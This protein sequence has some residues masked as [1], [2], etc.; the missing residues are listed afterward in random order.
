M[1]LSE[2]TLIRSLPCT[3]S[4]R[5]RPIASPCASLYVSVLSQ[6]QT[7]QRTGE[8]TTSDYS[9]LVN[10]P[11]QEADGP[12]SRQLMSTPPASK[13]VKGVKSAKSTKG[14]KSTKDTIRIRQL[15][16]NGVNEP[17]QE[18]DG[19]WSRQLK[20]GGMSMPS[21]S[22]STKSAKSTKHTIRTRQL[23]L[24]GV[25]QDPASSKSIARL[26]SFPQ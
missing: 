11:V 19:P 6:L 18:A 10:E 15:A 13:S 3:S 1:S 12:W 23:A 16:L 17:V 26:M 9:R 20:G 22:K 8:L 25:Q 24:N 2:R 7:P 14:A 21:A 4:C 5:A